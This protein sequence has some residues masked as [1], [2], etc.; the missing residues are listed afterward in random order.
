MRKMLLLLLAI[1]IILF[2]ACQ[3]PPGSGGETSGPQSSVPEPEPEDVVIYEEY[4]EFV[5]EEPEPEPEIAYEDSAASITPDFQYDVLDKE[6]LNPDTAGWLY[7]PDTT[8]NKVVLQNPPEMETNQFYLDV[9]FYRRPDKNGTFCTDFRNEFGFGTREEL[10]RI[11]TIYGHSWSDNP[12]GELFAQLKKFRDPEFARTHPY[13]FFSTREENMA[14]EVFAVFDTTVCLP[15]ITPDLND[16]EMYDLLSVVDKLSEY[17]YTGAVSPDDK[18][19][20][21]STCTFSV[22]GHERLPDI[23]DYRFVIMAKLVEPKAL[24]LDETAFF[25]NENPAFPDTVAGLMSEWKS[26]TFPVYTGK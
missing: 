23:N 1:L 13:I 14:W 2:P 22:R 25:V 12:D 15:Y 17:N 10:S 18:L 6:L 4:P 24:K 7:I 19:L 11:T 5:P 20:V 3:H 21:L 8:V 26:Y 16:N 9:D